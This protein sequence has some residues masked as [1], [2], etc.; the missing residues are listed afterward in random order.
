MEEPS[1]LKQIIAQCRHGI[2]TKW[3]ETIFFNIVAYAG[4]KLGLWYQVY[5]SH[6]S[7]SWGTPKFV[8]TLIPS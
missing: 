1:V 7:A 6:Q 3:K 5:I 4:Y 2:R 8:M